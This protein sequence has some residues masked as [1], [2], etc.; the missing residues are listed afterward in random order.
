[1]RSRR[2]RRWLLAALTIAMVAVTLI[3]AGPLAHTAKA[4]EPPRQAV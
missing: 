3:P 2:M 4:N 1:M